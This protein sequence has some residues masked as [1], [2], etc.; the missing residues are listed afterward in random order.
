MI[1]IF[2]TQFLRFFTKKCCFSVRTAKKLTTARFHSIINVYGSICAPFIC[3]R[4]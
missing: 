1:F 3:E 2:A 4:I